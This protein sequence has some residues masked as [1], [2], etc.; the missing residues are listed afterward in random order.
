[1]ASGDYLSKDEY[2]A[3]LKNELETRRKIEPLLEVENLLVD[4][5]EFIERSF[6]K[7]RAITATT[8]A[9]G[10]PQKLAESFLVQ[11]LMRPRFRRAYDLSRVRDL[12]VALSSLM[13]ANVFVFLRTSLLLGIFLLVALIG[14]SII[15]SFVVLGSLQ[16]GR[17]LASIYDIPW[18]AAHLS[19]IAFYSGLIFTGLFLG[20]LGFWGSGRLFRLS[21]VCVRSSANSLTTL[22]REEG[23]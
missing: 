23:P 20:V 4:A 7:G 8:D 15:L 12:R 9:L 5:D 14:W 21:W 22:D 13:R 17:F 1:M 19:V 10:T 16:E 3:D 18:T 11:A 6:R 2:L